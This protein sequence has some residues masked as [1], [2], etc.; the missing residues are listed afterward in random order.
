MMGLQSHNV[1]CWQVLETSG[2]VAT[3]EPKID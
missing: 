1:A 2:T 3:A